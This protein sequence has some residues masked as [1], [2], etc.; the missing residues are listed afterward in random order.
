MSK[1]IIF[2]LAQVSNNVAKVFSN[3]EVAG[4]IAL[5]ENE[6]QN[7]RPFAITQNGKDIG[8]EHC[9]VCAIEAVVR[10]FERIEL[11]VEVRLITPKE[12]ASS[13]RI[14]VVSIH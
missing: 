11:G 13:I 4:Y 3:G 14:N 8:Y 5:P 7:Q 1:T 9:E 2:K 12:P 10:R 6:H